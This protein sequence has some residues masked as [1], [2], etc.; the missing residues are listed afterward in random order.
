MFK[1]VHDKSKT[2]KLRPLL[3]LMKK[4]QTSITLFFSILFLPLCITAQTTPDPIWAT[5]YGGSLADI[6]AGTA[7]DAAG[8]IYVCGLYRQHK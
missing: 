6:I 1:P 2:M 8:N 3:T 7:K 5:Y 4:K